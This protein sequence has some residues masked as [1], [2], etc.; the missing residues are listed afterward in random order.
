MHFYKLTVY[1]R[2]L[3]PFDSLSFQS[4]MM[5]NDLSRE[6]LWRCHKTNYGRSSGH[7]TKEAIVRTTLLQENT[8]DFSLDH[9][10]QNP[11]KLKRWPIRVTMGCEKKLCE[12]MFC[13]SLMYMQ[14]Q[15]SL[16]YTQSI[17]G[18]KLEVLTFFVSHDVIVYYTL[19]HR[20]VT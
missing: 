12:E 3:R 10:T 5:N 8:E 19:R 9:Q 1:C 6:E 17:G 20:L 15:C 7:G 18:S 14:M 2:T 16:L 13:F 4:I 11:C